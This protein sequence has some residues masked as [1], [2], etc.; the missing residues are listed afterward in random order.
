MN[1]KP[2]AKKFRVRKSLGLAERT[3]ASGVPVPEPAKAAGTGN[4]APV[5]SKTDA[6]SVAKAA[7][8]AARTDPGA[9]SGETDMPPAPGNG[10]A[11]PLAPMPKT[12]EPTARQMRLARRLA[13]RR[14][15]KANTD[16]EAVAALR[17]QGVDPFG[18]NRL[19]IVPPKT[20]PV[21]GEGG[22]A[23][24]AVAVAPNVLPQIAKSP[25]VPVPSA[26]EKA[27]DRRAAE[28]MRMQQDI[29]VRRRRNLIG[30]GARIFAFVAA[31]TIAA[32]VYYSAIA[33][34]MYATNSQ[35]LIQQ[36]D[37]PAQSAASS[38]LA[39]TSLANSQD[40]IAVQSYLQSREAMLRLDADLGFKAHFSDPKID[41]LQR[42]DADGTN[43][44]AY[45]R[46]QRSVRIGYDPTEG[47]VRMEVIAADPDVSRD[48]SL[49]LIAYAEEQVDQLTQRIRHDQMAGALESYDDAELKML[50]AQK[51]VLD[52][53]EARGVLSAEAEVSSLMTQI[54]TF[55]VQL[56]Q[57]RLS[58]QSLQ[59]NARPNQTKVDVAKRTIGRLEALIA[60]MRAEMT[61]GTGGG[62]SLARISG[63]LVISESELETRQMM[64]AQSLQQ[65]ETARIEANRQVRYLLLGVSP[66]AP[67]EAAYPRAFENTVLAFLIFSGLYLMLS[68]TASIL[69]EQVSA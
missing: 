35:F 47:I 5:T 44:A 12:G 50:D 60:E 15:I 39:G 37:A 41:P 69:R 65:L 68:L 14:G 22:S 43:E 24:G 20:L 26:P 33:T 45:R 46:Y 36:A 31:P 23:T 27:Q 66:T 28:I 6:Q 18:K 53:Q 57:Q 56:K 2:R 16:A 63:E 38:L 62:A 32:S 1:T 48:Y 19:Q 59:D 55:E 17:A 3:T 21:A 7:G 34:P 42:L 29:A 67:D 49:A 54:S 64:F 25:P 61:Q 8:A 10:T 58:L 4:S 9:G 51:R 30:L 40:S 11:K 13:T 52:L